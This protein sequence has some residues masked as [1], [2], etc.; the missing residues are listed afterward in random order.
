MAIV[1]DL[2]LEVSHNCIYQFKIHNLIIIRTLDT[3]IN[4]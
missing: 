4:S 2:V 3:R 1:L